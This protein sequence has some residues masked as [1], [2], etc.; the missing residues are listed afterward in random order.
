MNQLNTDAPEDGSNEP[1]NQPQPTVRV[2]LITSI[3]VLI[4]THHVTTPVGVMLMF[5]AADM[6]ADAIKGFLDMFK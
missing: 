4:V 6:S 5:V 3:L 1:D 2:V